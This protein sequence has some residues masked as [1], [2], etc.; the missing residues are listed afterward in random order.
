K[1]EEFEFDGFVGE[2]PLD[3]MKIRMNAGLL[4]SFT[5]T[6]LKNDEFVA[7]PAGERTGP[8]RTTTQMEVTVWLMNMPMLKV[9]AQVS[10]YSLSII[11]DV[12]VIM[13]EVRRRLL[14][15]PNMSLSLDANNLVGATVRTA[16]GPRQPGL[17]DGKLD[18]SER[19]M[20]A[21]GISV[22]QNWVWASTKRNLDVLAFFD[23]LSD[24]NN[25]PISLYYID[26]KDIIDPPE[27][28]PGQLPN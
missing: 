17:V 8:I 15:N 25:E 11:Y 4:T 20:M 22:E 12:R 27:R 24:A 3:T 5:E 7:R 16:L 19:Q 2:S 18:D 13:P 14:V 28:F 9:S 10:H 26:D 21:S 23:Y 6:S 1:W